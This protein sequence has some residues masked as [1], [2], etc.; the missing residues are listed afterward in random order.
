MMISSLVRGGGLLLLLFSWSDI[1]ILLLSAAL[2]SIGESLKS[3]TLESW[4]L[5]KI[6]LI[7]A[8]FDSTPFFSKEKLYLNIASLII[9]FLGAQILAEIDIRLPF[10]IAPIILFLN[11][12]LVFFTMDND[13]KNRIDNNKIQKDNE[14]FFTSLTMG[15]KL[16]KDNPYLF[17]LVIAILPLQIVLS[18]PSSQ[19]QLF[20]NQK[21]TTIITGYIATLITLCAMLAHYLTPKLIAKFKNKISFFIFTTLVNAISIILTVISQ[22]VVVAIFFFAIHVVAMAAEQVYRYAALNNEIKSFN[23]ATVLSTFNIV[24]SGFTVICFSWFFIR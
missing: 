22:S 20:F 8:E 14:S 4:A 19:W 16:F 6:S 24:E 13:F 7:D 15:F 18:G 9:T 5:D 3:G 23:R 11:A 1:S 21:T 17:K 2:T 10:I 12:V